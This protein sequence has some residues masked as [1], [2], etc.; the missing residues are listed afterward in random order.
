MAEKLTGKTLEQI[1]TE[2]EKALNEKPEPMKGLK[3][4]FQFDI[5]EEGSYQLQ[6]ADGKAMITSEL[7]DTPDCTLQL[8]F[9]NFC[10]FLSGEMKGTAAFMTGK[11]KVQ[12]DVSKALKLE[13]LLKE[14]DFPV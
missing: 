10:K 14:Y 13:S 4:T 5:K 8:S 11:L 1:M 6:I 3:A 7:E 12:G 2:I 9:P